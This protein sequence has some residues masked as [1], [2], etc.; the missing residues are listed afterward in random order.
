MEDH[1]INEKKGENMAQKKNEYN[2]PKKNT[3]SAGIIV[4]LLI[5]LIISAG[6]LG[7][8]YFDQV[9]QNEK[10]ELEKEQLINE[11]EELS[12]EYE[13]LKTEN[14]TINSELEQR[15]VEI[16]RLIA[17][18]TQIKTTNAQIIRQYKKELG[19]LREIMKSYIVQIDS[20]NTKNVQLMAENVEVKQE[21]EKIKGELETEREIKEE[22]TEKVEI[23]SKLTAK[24]IVALSLNE[25]G[26]EKDRISKIAR[27]QVC[28]ALR[29]N[30]IAEPGP[31][32]IYIR[33]IRPDSVLLADSEENV[34]ELDGSKLVYSEKREI[35]Y[36]NQ[37]L[38]VCVFWQNNGMLI[39]GG[40]SID[41]YTEEN[42]IGT[43]SLMLR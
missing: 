6:V 13:L 8:L 30:P 4:F 19:T 21:I 22:L 32:M 33:I 5:I 26:K 31:R 12:K 24:N 29:E 23:G 35:E 34:F 38:D 25:K 1:N 11:F 18:I 36:E 16:E 37:D 20:L 42:L 9:K 15:Q 28:F 27:L 2:N 40:Y 14:D 10:V 41:L 39:P 7:Y 3:G 43:T 17:E